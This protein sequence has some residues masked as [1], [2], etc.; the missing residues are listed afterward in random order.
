MVTFVASS[1][2]HQPV[3]VWSASSLLDG[4]VERRRHRAVH[5]RAVGEARHAAASFLVTV[6]ASR[7]ARAAARP[8]RTAPS[9]VA[10]QPLSV[11]APAR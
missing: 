6:C 3:S 7:A 10:G 4:S 1:P 9:I 5:G 8:L 2:F 11:Q